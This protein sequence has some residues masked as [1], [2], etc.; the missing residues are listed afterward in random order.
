MDAKSQRRSER[1][2][3]SV[4]KHLVMPTGI[5]STEWPATRRTVRQ[6]L[7]V[8]FDRWQDGCGQVMLS[9][10]G[11]GRLAC[12]VGGFALSA[13]RQI[14]KTFFVTPT[15]F[16]LSIDKP[17][18]LSLWSAHHSRTHGETFLYMQAFCRQPR[19]QPFIENVFT[20]SGDEEVRFVNGSRI[21]FGARE[22]GFG[23]GV[24]NVDCEV[25]D[26]A[27]ILSVKA[28]E[29]MLAAMNRSMFGL[30][31]YLGTPPKQG[32]PCEAFEE[33]RSE[34]LAFAKDGGESFDS[35]WIECGADDDAD[36]DDWAQVA[37][38]NP[39]FPEHTSE[40]SI[41]RLRKRLGPDG[42]RRE[43]L[44][45]WP[46]N[47]RTV[48]D[49]AGWVS[50]EDRDAAPPRRVALVVH[51][52]EFRKS[53]AIAVAGDGPGGSVLLL[54]M[55]GDGDGW[56]TEKIVELVAARDIA[57]VALAPGEARGLEGSLTRAGVE[58]KKLTGVDIAASCTAFQSAVTRSSAAMG[59]DEAPV[60]KHTGQRELD[61]AVAKGKTKRVGPSETW[62]D[63]T[64]SALIAAAAAYH[65]WTMQEAPIPA[66][67]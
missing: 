54:V 8:R 39:S 23:R 7:G 9:K 52:A 5:V 10:R 17:G 66:I 67:Y 65:R 48:F 49:L 20:G 27:Q 60:L 21:L 51:V 61:G 12:T 58:F 57:E 36:L 14:G 44:G 16:A 53:A 32:D 28:L 38:A 22:R 15:L 34:A 4:A 25:F 33:M 6:K 37:K 42:F 41:L 30:H 35:A 13:P 50:L 55:A 1:P 31:A 29:N 63:G 2:L 56:I 47:I 18:L 46:G 24:P 11:N 43:G 3:S 59:R 62:E 40:E 45:I 19:V 26:E 64:D